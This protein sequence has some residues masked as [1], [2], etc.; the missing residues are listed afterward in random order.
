MTALSKACASS[1]KECKDKN[2]SIDQTCRLAAQYIT[3]YDVNNGAKIRLQCEAVIVDE[4]NRDGQRLKVEA[5]ISKAERIANIGFVLDKALCICVQLPWDGKHRQRILQ[6]NKQWHVEDNRMPKVFEEHAANTGVGGNH[7][8]TFG[9]M[10][11]QGSP[12]ESAF[13]ID[14]LLSM[15]QMRLKD[16]AFY[17]NI[18]AGLKWTQLAAKIRTPVQHSHKDFCLLLHCDY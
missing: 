12:V 5:I 7:L 16:E 1:D 14:G 17:D 4:D 11:L 3:K 6:T 18:K 8:N 13:S 10:M 9:R 15:E 2:D